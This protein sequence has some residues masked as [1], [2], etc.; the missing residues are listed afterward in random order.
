MET[1]AATALTVSGFSVVTGTNQLTER[2]VSTAGD[3]TSETTA[4]TSYTDL[5]AT[6][7]PSVTVLTGTSAIVSV[8][9]GFATSGGTASWVSYEVSGATSI[10]A[11]DSW[12]LQMHV[13]T[14]PWSGSAVSMQVGLTPGLNTFTMKYRVSTSGTGTFTSRRLAVVPF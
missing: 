13:T 4:E 6:P 12:A 5:E 7:G 2:L 9:A 8:F 14:T 10:E 1:E 11:N 3:T